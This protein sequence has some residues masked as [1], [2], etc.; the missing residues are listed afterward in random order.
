L[1]GLFLFAMVNLATKK[2]WAT[3]DRRP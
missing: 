1:A 3:A 2:K